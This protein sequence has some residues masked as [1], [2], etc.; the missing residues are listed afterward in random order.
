M[1]PNVLC[2][3]FVFILV[4]EKRVSQESAGTVQS[5]IRYTNLTIQPYLYTLMSGISSRIDVGKARS[6]LERFKI[7]DTSFP[8]G[9]CYTF[10]TCLEESKN[11]LIFFSTRDIQVSQ[12]VTLR[13]T[14][15]FCHS[16]CHKKRRFCHNCDKRTA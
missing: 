14:A 3:F 4:E 8:V 12:M 5:C 16:A 1:N 13:D 7:K 10:L 15:G 2:Q 9:I 6:Y 11:K